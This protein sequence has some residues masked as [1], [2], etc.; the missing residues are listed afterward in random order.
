[1]ADLNGDEVADLAVVNAGSKTISLFFGTGSG[2]PS[3]AS[4]T[5]SGTATNPLRS[6]RGIVL[7]DFDGDG[8]TDIAVTSFL[9]SSVSVFLGNENPMTSKG[10]GTFQGPTN[11]PVPGKPLGIAVGRFRGETQP[12]DLAVVN[13]LNGQ[14][15]NV[16]KVTIFLGNG[17]GTFVLEGHFPTGRAPRQLAVGDFGSS[18]DAVPDGNLDL[19]V[20]LRGENELAVLYGDGSGGF[21][22]PTSYNGTRP[23][24]LAVGDYDNDGCPDIALADERPFPSTGVVMK[25]GNCTGSV[26][27]TASFVI[28]QLGHAGPAGITPVKLNGDDNVDLAVTDKRSKEIILLLNESAAGGSVQFSAPLRCAVG[29]GPAG[30]TAADFNGDAIDDLAVANRRSNNVSI[31]LGDGSGTSC[32]TET[33]IGG[34]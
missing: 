23:Q 3:T 10:D 13:A 26:S 21:G 4:A 24:G 19:A 5:L 27:F 15:G 2:L 32:P 20:T 33:Q 11:Y 16:G 1:M 12:V 17:D 22:S 25:L 18:M 6:P 28:A 8:V 34:P 31:L 14:T 7:G 30:V 9:G 29:A